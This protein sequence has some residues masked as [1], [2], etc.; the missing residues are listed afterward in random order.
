MK[1]TTE[2]C[3][4]GAKKQSIME[5]IEPAA[6]MFPSALERFAESETFAQA[7]SV[8]VGNPDEITIPLYTNDMIEQAMQ[9]LQNRVRELENALE[10]ASDYMPIETPLVR[11]GS[12]QEDIK[13][14]HDA[15]ANTNP[16]SAEIQRLK[17]E[18]EV[19]QTLTVCPIQPSYVLA[20]IR[21]R[22]ARLAELESS[23]GN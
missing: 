23:T 3:L 2:Q 14:V 22:R 12:T 17:V 7:F 20:V 1:L 18:I 19:L 21:L 16:N 5:S 9:E 11:S 13:L 4:E 6:Y 8:E 10:R 15:L